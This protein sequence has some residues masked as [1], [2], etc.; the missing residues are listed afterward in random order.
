MIYGQVNT[1]QSTIPFAVPAPVGGLNGRD[2]LANMAPTDA[3]LMDNMY[4]DTATV[5]SFKG[6]EKYTDAALGAP[7]QTLEVYAGA[8][9][10]Q[11]LA[12][13]GT[14]IFDVSAPTPV[15]IET[16]MVSAVAFNAMFSNAADNAQHLISV[17]GFDTPKHYDGSTITDLA[18]TGPVDAS[19]LNTVLAF[20]ERLYFTEREKLGFWFLPVGQ[21]QGAASYF[22]LAQVSR[23][24]GALLTIATFSASDNGETPNDYIVFITTKGEC[25][26]YNGF[27]PSNAASW[28]LVGRYFSATPI[29][30]KCTLN[31]N[32]ELLILTLEGALPFSEIRKSGTAQA[33]GVTGSARSAITSKLGKFLSDFNMNAGVPGWQGIQYPLGGWLVLNVPSTPSIGGD[34][35]HYIMNTTTGA[36]SRR[37]NWNGMCFA[38]FNDRLYF[39]RFDGYVM[40][41]DEGRNDDGQDILCDVKQA[42]NYFAD[43]RGAG[44]L[45]KHFQWASLLVSCDGTPPLSGKFNTDFK[46]EQPVYLNTLAETSGSAWD[47]EFWDVAEWGFDATVQRA[48][49]TLNRGGFVG[50]LWL[51]A[52]L[53][54][55]KLDWYATQYTM[56]KTNGLLI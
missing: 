7:V 34:Y 36:W 11:L 17:T 29:G 1:R 16:G 45:I 46:E 9:G 31:Y 30:T 22:D 51:R 2:P 24:G 38:V 28:A 48:I 6:T 12:W 49:I 33:S 23:L 37:T 47:T 4:P 18:I 54:G 42:Y 5:A 43:D 35:Y 39:G 21:I 10:D 13:A 41:A 20:K 15:E 55:I 26:V 53:D 56:Q 14:K 19:K 3:Y 40:L 52:S 44:P 27:D 8:E 32:G 50:A 25:I